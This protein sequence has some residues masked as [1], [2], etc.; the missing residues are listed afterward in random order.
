MFEV[1]KPC[2]LSDRYIHLPEYKYFLITK[3]LIW[4]SESKLSWDQNVLPSGSQTKLGYLTN[5]YYVFFIL[6]LLINLDLN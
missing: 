1:I 6:G 2:L 5:Y 4:T 3:T